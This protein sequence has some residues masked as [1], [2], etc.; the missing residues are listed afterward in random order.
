MPDDP[1]IVSCP[2]CDVR[3]QFDSLGEAREFVETHRIET[4]HDP[5]WELPV[6]ASGVERAGDEAG[7]CGRP[8][9]TD[10]DSPLY[11]NE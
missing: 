6:L 4:G 9:C 1:V 5:D 8:G 7:V 10:T 2:D 3:E 11:R